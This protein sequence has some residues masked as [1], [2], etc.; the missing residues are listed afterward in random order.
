MQEEFTT[1]PGEIDHLKTTREQKSLVRLDGAALTVSGKEARVHFFDDIMTP[2]QDYKGVVLTEPE[3][4][5]LTRQMRKLRTGFQAVMPIKCAGKNAC[6]FARN[7]PLVELDEDNPDRENN[8]KV[9]VGR[10]CPVE[11]QLYGMWLMDYMSHLEI[12]PDDLF[13][14]ML[15]KEL[16]ELDIYEWRVQNYLSQTEKAIGVGQNVVGFDQE[17]NTPIFMEQISAAMDLKL[18]LKDRRQRILEALVGTRKEQYKKQAALQQTPTTD[19][20][21]QLA[22]FKAKLESTLADR[23]K[24]INLKENNGSFTS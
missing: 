21:H 15:C 18:K 19:P 24:I 6:P 2:L 17:N 9:P 3:V 14:V 11:T 23:Q 22:G 20:S 13:D 10:N 4:L 8:P 12:T 16:A 7:C 1:L 5:Y